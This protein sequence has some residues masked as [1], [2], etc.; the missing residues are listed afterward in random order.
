MSL[1]PSQN[2]VKSR[3]ARLRTRQ[4]RGAVRQAPPQADFS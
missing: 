2:H 1:R 3:G 4:H